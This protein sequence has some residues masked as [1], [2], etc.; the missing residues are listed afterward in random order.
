MR[1]PLRYWGLLL[2]SGGLYGSAFSW[3]KVSVGDGAPVLGLLFWFT[4]LATIVLG[5]V[6]TVRRRW[7]RPSVAVLRFCLGWAVVSVLV[8]NFLFFAAAREIQA[9]LIALAIALVPLLTLLGGIAL[10]RETVTVFRALGLIL[11]ASAVLIV[12]VPDTSLPEPRDSAFVLLAFLGALFYAIEHLYIDA[13]FPSQTSMDYLLFLMFGLASALLVPAVIL[14][15]SF[16]VPGTPFGTRE[17][18]VLGLSGVT[19]LDYFLVTLLIVRA[20]PVFASQAAYVVTIAGVLWGI[21]LL[22][23]Q[24]SLWVW[25]AVFL[26][27]FGL[28]LVHPRVDSIKS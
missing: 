28:A 1:I 3:M 15:N 17:L 9:G 5:L 8:P 19:L 23:E 16:I 4:G 20:G 10:R 27:L 2:L 12:L 21:V 24:H 7:R 11:G 14:T 6:L 26:L 22:G 13:R 25:L 18:A